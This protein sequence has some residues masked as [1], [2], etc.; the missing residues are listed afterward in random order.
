MDIYLVGGAVRDTLLGLAVKDRDWVVVGATPGQLEQQ[1]YQRVGADFPVFLHPGS[2]EEYAL[3]RTERKS[4][5]GYTGFEV[6]FSPDVTLEDDLL[7]RDL[8][9]NAM[10]RA[11]D[12]T[13]VDPYGGRADL[14]ARLLRHVSPAFREDPLRV[15]RVARFAARFDHLG[16]SL[17]DDTR[18]LM[19]EMVQAGELA[20][21]VPER[22]WQEM[23]RALMEPNPEVF[24]QVLRAC[25]ALRVVFPALDALF[26]VPQPMRWHPE[27]DT[28]IHTLK[29][30]Q[31]AVQMDAPLEVRVATLSHDLGKALTETT[32]WPSHRGH[33]DLG[34]DLIRQHAG[35]WRWPKKAAALAEHMARYHTHCHRIRQLRPATIVSTLN[36]LGAFRHSE[37]FRQFLQACE[38]DARGR[39]GLERQAYPQAALFERCLAACESVLPADLVAQGYQ[40]AELGE[41]L[42]RER[43]RAVA[44]EKA[45][46]SD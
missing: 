23:S 34:A 36:K 42:N 27:V 41:A 16:F 22:I 1:G 43:V 24:F 5:H 10:A 12:G 40:G 28:G 25:G 33:E 2:K 3:A 19:R 35:D 15:L 39:S 37:H 30:L 13:L 7:R 18:A 4:G 8:T 32:N 44:Q 14:D 31:I 45:T 6:Q 9:I 17:A 46:W 26:G 11:E 38:C 21:L 20:Y 29:A